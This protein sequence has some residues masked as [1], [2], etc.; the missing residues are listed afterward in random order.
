MGVEEIFV[1]CVVHH[2]RIAGKGTE[3]GVNNVKCRFLFRN[4]QNVLALIYKLCNQAGDGLGFTRAGRA[5]NYQF[6]VGIDRVQNGFLRRVERININEGIL[7]N[8]FLRIKVI[9]GII[10]VGIEVDCSII[11]NKVGDQTVYKTLV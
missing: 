1:V 6:V 8:R 3:T 11:G 10:V 5:L 7:G 9:F 2:N 4:H